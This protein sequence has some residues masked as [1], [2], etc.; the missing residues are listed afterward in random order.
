MFYDAG[1]RDEEANGNHV[2]PGI[3]D[4]WQLDDEDLDEVDQDDRSVNDPPLPH[5]LVENH[6][7]VDHNNNTG[8]APL[9]TGDG[10]NTDNENHAPLDADTEPSPP[11]GTYRLVHPILNGISYYLAPSNC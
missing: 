9:D 10:T 3:H 4:G 1:N 2:Y 8:H 5:D 6:W 11:S 7:D